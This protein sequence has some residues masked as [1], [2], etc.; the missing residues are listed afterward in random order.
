[1]PGKRFEC[2]DLLNIVVP[3]LVRPNDC[4]AAATALISM[5]FEGPEA[6]KSLPGSDASGNVL[7]ELE[8]DNL[9]FMGGLIGDGLAIADVGLVT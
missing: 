5:V 8:V 2:A 1:M 3:A 9:G 6:A 4:A 7:S